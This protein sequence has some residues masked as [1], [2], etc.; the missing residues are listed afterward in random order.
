M[1]LVLP[2]TNF[3]SVISDKNDES[4]R[5]E[6]LKPKMTNTQREKN[7]FPVILRMFCVFSALKVFLIWDLGFICDVK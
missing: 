7:V 2:V 6:G 1:P 5:I 3:Q 4:D